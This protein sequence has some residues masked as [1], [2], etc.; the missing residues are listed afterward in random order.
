[1]PSEVGKG[2]QDTQ[3]INGVYSWVMVSNFVFPSSALL[4]VPIRLV[5]QNCVM[6]THCQ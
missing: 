4:N 1:M 3:H 2:L 6:T 5:L